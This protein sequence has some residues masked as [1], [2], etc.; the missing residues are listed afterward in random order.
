METFIRKHG[1]GVTAHLAQ[2]LEGAQTAL[3]GCLF[4]LYARC[5][6]Q[7][8]EPCAIYNERC[9]LWCQDTTGPALAC[10]SNTIGSMMDDDFRPKP[11]TRP[12]Y[13][14]EY[15]RPTRTK[16][17]E[18]LATQDA[19][20][21][22]FADNPMFSGNR[23]S[24]DR[25]KQKKQRKADKVLGK[26]ERGA[27]GVAMVAANSESGGYLEIDAFGQPTIVADDKVGTG[28]YDADIMTTDTAPGG[29]IG[30][31]IYT[32]PPPPLSEASFPPGSDNNYSEAMMASTNVYGIDADADL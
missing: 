17:P 11:Y 2:V 21:T 7:F 6:I 14:G 29:D 30:G 4:R 15:E 27:H 24:D 8:C 22:F 12:V 3:P 10:I 28:Y 9:D 13:R 32:I 16:M 5:C 1:V 26:Q 19:P 18:P 23:P 31:G 20:H 25:S